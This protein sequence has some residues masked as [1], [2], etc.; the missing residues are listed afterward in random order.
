MSTVPEA[1]QQP[2]LRADARRNVEKLRKAAAD[3]FSAHG[4]DTPLETIAKLAGVSVGTIY[5]RFGNRDALM[6]QVVNELADRQVR[7]AMAVA[8]GTTGSAWDRLLAYIEAICQSQADD[9]AFNDAFSRRYPNA[10]ALKAVCD[11]SLVFATELAAGARAEGAL[12]EDAHMDDIARF[13]QVNGD[14]VRA[15]DDA[16]RRRVLTL[17][18]EGLRARPG[19]R[20]L[21]D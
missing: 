7:A 12:R 13:F 3:A 15:G 16:G 1:P 9:P 18:F 17:L 2:A 10:P 11:R 4:L 8:D 20:P 19:S 5:N 6:D 21:P 14:L